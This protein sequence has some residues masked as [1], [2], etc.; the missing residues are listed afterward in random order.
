MLYPKLPPSPY[1][2]AFDQV[3]TA[4]QLHQVHELGDPP[5]PVPACSTLSI[6]QSPAENREKATTPLYIGGRMPPIP[7][8]LANR[9]QDGQFVE[10]V[11]LLP[12]LL[13]GYNP[14][15]E[16]QLKGRL[17]WKNDLGLYFSLVLVMKIGMC[18]LVIFR[19]V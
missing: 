4:E 19:L 12:D 16:D 14:S 13:R 17:Q 2:V 6:T 10:I 9:I 5:N 15:D 18:D 11:E 1:T 8:K 7:A 3:P